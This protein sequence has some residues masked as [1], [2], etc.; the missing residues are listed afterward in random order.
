MTNTESQFPP[1]FQPTQANSKKTLWDLCPST[2]PFLRSWKQ[3]FRILVPFIVMGRD[4]SILTFTLS[5]S[6]AVAL[7]PYCIRIIIIRIAHIFLPAYH[8]P[9]GV[10][11]S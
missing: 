5:W 3:R 2:S 6:I 9:L 8:T 11:A 1:N 4:V 10:V 7:A